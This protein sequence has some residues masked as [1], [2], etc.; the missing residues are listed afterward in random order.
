MSQTPH[1]R[2]HQLREAELQAFKI[3]FDY[4]A[5]LE[6]RIRILEEGKVNRE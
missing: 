3:L 5:S 4:L 2:S 6:E 1:S